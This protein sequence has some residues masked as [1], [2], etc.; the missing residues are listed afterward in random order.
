M[1]LRTDAAIMD[2]MS[3]QEMQEVFS[4]YFSLYHITGGM[5][6]KFFLIGSIC[7][8]THLAKQKTPGITHW[9]IIKKLTEDMNLPEKF[10][11]GL[12]IMC[13]DFSYE[14]KEFPNFGIP[15]KEI[16]PKVKEILNSWMP[17]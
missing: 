4:E 12:A 9:H 11:M 8:L 16:I 7:K 15:D 6:N 14:T 5:Q 1:N 13:D 10:L 2:R 17:F 3:Y